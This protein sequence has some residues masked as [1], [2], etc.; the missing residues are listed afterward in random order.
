MPRRRRKRT[1]T[2]GFVCGALGRSMPRRCPAVSGGSPARTGAG[3]PD[4]AQ[5]G[6]GHGPEVLASRGGCPA[7]VEAG[8]RRALRAFQLVGWN[9][10]ARGR[11]ASSSRASRPGARGRRGRR[12][13]W[14]RGRC[15]GRR[16]RGCRGRAG[17]PQGR[18][19]LPGRRRASDGAGVEGPSTG[20][21]SERASEGRGRRAHG[22]PVAVPPWIGSESAGAGACE[23]AAGAGA[24]TSTGRSRRGASGPPGAGARGTARPGRPARAPG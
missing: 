9:G 5:T 18:C 21:S 13:A 12:R 20:G 1:R 16:R 14:R 6:A 2:S 10:D 7:G 4:G 3:G 8:P 23:G 17:A 15:A 22:A 24:F 19:A 11:A